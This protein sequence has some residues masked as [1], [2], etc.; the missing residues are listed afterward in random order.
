MPSALRYLI[1]STSIG[2]LIAVFLLIFFPPL[3]NN[4]E[5]PFAEQI[6]TYS[7]QVDSYSNAV[8][9][10]APAVVNIYSQNYQ[11]SNI[12]SQPEL[13]PTGLGSGII[14]SDKGYVLT[15]TYLPL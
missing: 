2:L 14:M 6:E 7:G 9:R 1:K 15:N 8:R 10:A 4:H 5:L 11:R 12:N 3:R 13:R